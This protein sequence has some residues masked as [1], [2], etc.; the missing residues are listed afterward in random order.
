MLVVPLEK[1]TYS[2]RQR[3]T[4][5]QDLLFFDAAVMSGMAITEVFDLLKD[6]LEAVEDFLVKAG[7]SAQVRLLS[8]VGTHI[9]SGGGKRFRA[10]LTL[11]SGR[12]TGAPRPRI[13]PLAGA[14][15]L[16]HTATLLHD[17]VVD[18]ATMR[19][20][21][22]AANVIWGDPAG[23]VAADFQFSSAFLTI[24]TYGGLTALE[25]V[26]R[27]IQAIVEGELLQFLRIGSAELDE[28]EYRTIISRKTAQ[29]ISTA[30]HVGALAGAGADKAP[31]LARYGLDVGM[32]FQ[33]I[34]DVLDYTSTP[35]VLGK[36]VGTDFREAK[37]TL[38]LIVAL[39]RAGGRERQRLL[40]LLD[41]PEEARQEEF[42]WARQVVERHRGFAYT[43]EAARDH[44]NKALR[45]LASFP[46][47]P[48][49]EALSTLALYVVERKM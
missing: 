30:C 35:E 45:E 11:L 24:L 49:R 13:V 25:I 4:F 42:L 31:A 21:R 41:G 47:S 33:M 43:L 7:T 1:T 28:A 10:T 18:T 14:I 19:R 48:E 12:I 22:P 6:D 29:L 38:P 9:L 46:R 5:A 34:D 27:T 23:V 8:K 3:G 37:F 40:E 15:E 20:G 17:D 26:N 36:Q 2:C 44:V 16:V 32:A 39:S